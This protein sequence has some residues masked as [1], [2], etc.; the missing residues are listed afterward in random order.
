[1]HFITERFKCTVHVDKF[2]I[3]NADLKHEHALTE[4][5]FTFKQ[6]KEKENLNSIVANERIIIVHFRNVYKFQFTI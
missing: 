3:I 2:I 5:Q 6:N 1:M 4:S